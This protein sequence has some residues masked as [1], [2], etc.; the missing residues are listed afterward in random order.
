MTAATWLSPARTM[1]AQRF[2]IGIPRAYRLQTAAPAASLGSRTLRAIDASRRRRVGDNEA[3][4]VFAAGCAQ[5]RGHRSA[6]IAGRLPLSVGGD[7]GAP[8]AKCA[9]L[10]IELSARCAGPAQRFTIDGSGH[11]RLLLVAFGAGGA[12]GRLVAAMAAR[13][14]IAPRLK[15]SGVVAERAPRGIDPLNPVLAQRT[16]QPHDGRPCH[17]ETVRAC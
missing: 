7:R 17:A 1:A 9:H 14:A 13:S 10:V 12:A 3:R 2:S 6:V 4:F 15:A 16:Y 5:G 8:A 11:D